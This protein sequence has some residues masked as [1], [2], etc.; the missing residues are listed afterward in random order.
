M[1]T[2]NQPEKKFRAGSIT[3]TVWQN[4][5]HKDGKET[6]YKTVSLDRVYKDKNDEWQNTSVMRINDLPKA[7]LVLTKAYEYII[8]KNK[9]TA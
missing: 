4:I 6:S 1:E 2:E 9:A 7:A 8:T 5:S 3:A